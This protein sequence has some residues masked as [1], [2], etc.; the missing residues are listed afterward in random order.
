MYSSLSNNI[1]II[2]DPLKPI[3]FPR[4]LFNILK[5]DVDVYDYVH[6]ILSNKVN[7]IFDI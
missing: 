4:K 2:C 6:L 5:H 1:G 7:I 3:H